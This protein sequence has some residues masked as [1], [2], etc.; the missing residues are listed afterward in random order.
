MPNTKTAKKA[1]K[2]NNKRRLANR[3]Q[4]STLKTL[5][6]N[7]RELTAEGKVDEATAALR[8]VSKRLDQAG[9]KHLYHPNKSARL[10]S[11]LAKLV[12][13]AGTKA[14]S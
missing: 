11:R 10:K 12:S 1:L 13:S 14:E 6:K 7:V 2:Q 3:S 9:A 5:I 8:L 4:R